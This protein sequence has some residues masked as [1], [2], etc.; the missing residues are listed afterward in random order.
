[1]AALHKANRD[2]FDPAFS[3]AVYGLDKIEAYWQIS[4]PIWPA[5]WLAWLPPVVLLL[6]GGIGVAYLVGRRDWAWRLAAV[7]HLPLTLT[8]APAFAFVMLTGHL[9][10]VDERDRRAFG[11]TFRRHRW[12]LIPAS[13]GLT[14]VSLWFH[15]A[16]VEWSMV[17]KECILWF[18]I[19]WVW[20]TPGRHRFALP[21]IQRRPVSV[22]R[23]R[24]ASTFF[25]V[26]FVC[27][28]L[29]PYTGLKIQHAFAMLS[30]L[31]V[32]TGCWNSSLV[33]ETFR[34]SDGY[35]R[36]DEVYFREPGALT[37]YEDIV[38]RGLWSPPQIRQM[39]RNW[40]SEKLRP[41]YLA[42][43]YKGVDFVIADACDL[44]MELPFGE[45]APFGVAI[46]GNYLRFQKNL[47]R[48]C[49]Q[50]CLH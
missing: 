4:Y 45:W 3:C 50:K 19:G 15:G 47:L 31:R 6:E 43:I 13:L 7:F 25:V 29:S 33:S 49:P 26:A 10:F 37:E 39:Q 12:W 44:E 11:E 40:C 28:G 22:A 30:N 48:R 16:P 35:I 38:T 17:P 21:S 8:M 41:F 42:G 5:E 14:Y 32:D 9:A 24:F 36:V 34:V 27:N 2:F 46:F 23:L 1:L 20:L 18:V